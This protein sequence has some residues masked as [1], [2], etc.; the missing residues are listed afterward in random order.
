MV[1]LFSNPDTWWA[2]LQICL[3]NVVLSGD[4]AVVIALA[5]RSLPPQQAKRAYMVGAIGIIVIMTGLTTAASY[6][7]DI[8]YVSMIGSVLLIWIAI[9]LLVSDDE[10]DD[11]ESSAH[12]WEAVKIIIIADIVMELDNVL[13]MAAVAKGKTWMLFVGLLMTV[14]LILFGSSLI[15]RLMERFP[16]VITLGALLLGYV[17]GEMIIKDPVL[18]E[19]IATNIPNANIIFPIIGASIVIGSG[20]FIEFRN[21]ARRAQSSSEANEAN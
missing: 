6:L 5:C 14:P 4:N 21:K 18:A 20:K 12:F 13:D 8:P 11:L 1:E 10:N 9:K 2:L 7:L 3:I 15:M 19:Y 17:S 16:I